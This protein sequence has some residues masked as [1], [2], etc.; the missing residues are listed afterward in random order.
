MIET[1][2]IDT[3][4]Y[5]LVRKMQAVVH[6]CKT[7][8]Q[9]LNARKY[10]LRCE[11]HAWTKSESYVA[12][13]ITE[14]NDLDKVITD[15]LVE[16]SD[17]RGIRAVDTGIIKLGL[18]IHGVIDKA[19]ELFTLISQLPVEVHIITGIKE[20]LDDQVPSDLKYD[21]WFSIHQYL[22]DNGVLFT[23]DEQNRPWCDPVL[24]DQAKADYCKREGITMLIDD[25][26][27]YVESFATLDTLYLQLTN[28]KR[29]DWRK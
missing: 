18:D 1:F 8:E 14:V 19:P 22:E 5:D 9:L 23:Y 27:N 11:E 2:E 25:S 28:T 7:E 17:T 24:W 10:L 15:K 29:T 20:H 12:T 3:H 16:L 21:K 6:S 26:P 4:A 13:I